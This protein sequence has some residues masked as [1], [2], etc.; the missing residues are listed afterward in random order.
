MHN[1]SDFCLSECGDQA[2]QL[3]EE[4]AGFGTKGDCVA[5]A[6]DVEGD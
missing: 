2:K 4:E 5:E 1:L 3:P 6:I